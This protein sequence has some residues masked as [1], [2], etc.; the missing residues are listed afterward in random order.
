M[1]LDIG[2]LTREA[3]LLF[4]EA[5]GE[6]S[7]LRGYGEGS[8]G[9]WVVDCDAS[10]WLLEWPLEKYAAFYLKPC[11]GALAKVIPPDVKLSRHA[12]EI[13]RGVEI[14]TRQMYRG[15]A[16]RG[17]IM[18]I[19]VWPYPETTHMARFDVIGTAA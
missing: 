5:L 14:G 10:P 2:H 18:P 7:D 9:H 6:G 1:T 17:I 15:V 12:P 13:P 4:H 16:M 11:M 3:L 19:M 8:T